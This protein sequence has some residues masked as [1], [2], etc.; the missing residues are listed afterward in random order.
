MTG[1]KGRSR[2][3]AYLALVLGTIGCVVALIGAVVAIWLGMTAGRTVDNAVARITTPVARLESR[4]AE[5]SDAVAEAG[6][7]GE[8]RARVQGIIDLAVNAGDSVGAIHDHP[9]FGRLP[10]DT[11]RI[12]ELLDLVENTAEQLLA[13]LG[14]DAEPLSAQVRN[15]ITSG[16]ASARDQLASVAERIDEAGASLRRWVRLAAIAAVLVALWG[17]WAQLAL[18]RHG[19]RVTRHQE[20][21]SP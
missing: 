15:G 9:L 19:W 3:V 5:T 1:V 14:D 16:V 8:V 12:T 7:G 18:A 13:A 17:L 2:V 6:S 10:V 4:L 20:G 11:S 21:K